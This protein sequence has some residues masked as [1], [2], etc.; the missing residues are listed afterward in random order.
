MTATQDFV[1]VTGIKGSSVTSK[2]PIPENLRVLPD[3]ENP[4][5]GFGVIRV[6]TPKDGDKR[7][8]WDSNDYAQINDAKV[9]FD[10]LVSQ[11]LVPYKVGT[12]G[13]AT[14]QVMDRFDPA[15]EEV[16]F[17]PVAMVTGG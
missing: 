5:R 9:M 14:S 2:I 11:G 3:G 10:E 12:D 15:A 1:E 6:M 16:I 4:Q 8:V 7:V 13:R 17:V